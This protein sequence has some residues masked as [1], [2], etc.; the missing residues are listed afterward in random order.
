VLQ[1]FN[2]VDRKARSNGTPRTSERL[3]AIVSPELL[4]ARRMFA[5]VPGA[6]ADLRS[7]IL[8][9]QGTIAD[10]TIELSLVPSPIEGAPHTIAVMVNGLPL[11]SFAATG[12]TRGVQ[13]DGRAG[14][15]VI[16]LGQAGAEPSGFPFAAIITGGDGNDEISGGDGNDRITGGNGMDT[17]LGG[18]G[19]DSLDGGAGD[20]TLRG[21][22]GND[23]LDGGATPHDVLEG[24]AGIDTF[25]K[26]NLPG[27]IID[28]EPTDIYIG[29]RWN[30]V[31]SD[32]FNGSGVDPTLW[33]VADNTTPNYDGGVN[34]YL[35]QNVNVSDGQLVIS[36]GQ[37]NDGSGGP[38]K[39]DSG[40]VVSKAGWRYG[41]I[42]IRAKLP[43]TQGIWPAMWMLPTNGSWPPEIDIMEMLGNAPNKVYMNHHWGPRSRKQQDQSDFAGPDFTTDYH[44]FALEWERGKLQWFI[45][46]VSRKVTARNVPDLAMEL[47]L[48]TSVGGKWP[49]MPDA[50]T[51]FPQ[52]FDVDYV[53]VF[54]HPATR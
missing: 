38:T 9:V 28:L 3:T 50:T 26:R 54:Q 4:E 25:A 43:G 6:M 41:R 15:D 34:D 36:S 2:R 52:T 13:I 46:G 11:A 29:A 17:L 51:A 42:E 27:E 44:V 31:W 53:R 35:P 23:T 47:I 32:E 19:N 12:I 5:A 48:N 22:S 33:Q 16:R 18:A 14:D 1:R 49:G 45:D 24:G 40:R 10:D 20:D 37:S 21:G 8:R 7:G 39:Y 30:M